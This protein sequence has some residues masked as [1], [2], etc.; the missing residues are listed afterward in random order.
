MNISAQNIQAELTDVRKG[1]GGRIEEQTGLRIK[2]H[3]LDLSAVEDSDEQV[4][5]FQDWG[6]VGVKA[7]L[8][9]QPFGRN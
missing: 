8:D 5:R 4:K 2:W 3:I 9:L 1:F 7:G 6:R